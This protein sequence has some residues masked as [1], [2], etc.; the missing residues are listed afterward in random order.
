M[1]KTRIWKWLLLA[2]FAVGSLAVVYPP[3]DVRSADGRLLKTGKIR[4]GLDLKGGS[5][6]VV[7]VDRDALRTQLREENPEMS[8]EGLSDRVAGD[9]RTARDLALE[10]IRNRVDG[11]GIAEP[12]IYPQGEDRIVIQLP[13]IDAAKREE[14]RRTIQSVAFL[15]FRLVHKSSDKWV[16][17]LKTDDLAPK[18]FRWTEIPDERD[19]ET[20]EVLVRDRSA[21]ED[22][23]MD[24]VYWAQLKRFEPH[25]GA[26]FMLERR[27]AADRSVVYKPRYVETAQQLT[28]KY[29]KRASVDYD[30]L[31]RPRISIEFD[32]IGRRRFAQVTRDYAPQGEKNRGNDVG[33]Q[34][35]IIL[36]G[37]LYS[38]PVIR[39][40]IPSGRAEITGQFTIPEARRLS[41]VLR[42]GSLPAPLRLIEERTVDPTLGR[43]SIRTGVRASIIAAALTAAFMAI[44]YFLPGWLANLALL[45]DILLLPLGMWLMAGFLNFFGGLSHAA[46]GGSAQFGALPT[47]TLPGI[48]GIALTLG[49]AVDANVLIFERIREEQKAGK[50]LQ[51]VVSAGYEKAWT[52]ILDSNLTTLLAAV[53]MFWQGSG[54]VR[55]YAITLSAGIVVS[56]YTAIAITRMIFDRMIAN[57]RTEGFRM[58]E[59][60]RSANFDFLGRK[61]Y[62][63]GFSILLTVASV[64]AFVAKGERNFGVDFRGGSSVSFEFKNRK[65]VADIR[66]ALDAAGISGANPQ[67]QG[68]RGEVGDK[69]DETLVV[70]GRFEDGQK[71]G[72]TITTQFGAD[73]YRVRQVDTV[74]PQVGE[75]LKRKGLM[76]L[77]WS[78]LGMII[79]I[80]WRFEFGYAIGA[81]VALL[82][83]AIV[84]VGVFCLFGRELSTPMIAVVLTI[85]GYSVNDTIVVFDRIR[86]QR[87]LYPEKKY[88]DVANLSINQTLSRTLL[89]GSTTIL[90]VLSLLFLGGGAINDFA[91]M[92]LIGVLIGTYSSIF[93]ATPVALLWHREAPKAAKV[94]KAAA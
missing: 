59:W 56:M 13:G 55:G 83:D 4:L 69:A 14:A 61:W 45:L 18:G 24:S 65:P 82:H 7:E 30:Q 48:A 52:T 94:A 34:L 28:G 23:Q 9:A 90:S 53:I 26:E 87:K 8:E 27:E 63:I 44:Y 40:E 22:E 86:E 11:L 10:A 91:L 51:A 42:T 74:G 25:E 16:E 89:T 60:I 71:I 43:D 68:A 35:A 50:R 47:L 46:G 78:M 19:R 3:F 15:E 1:D 12:A 70:Q 79:Y 39:E 49:M 38:S 21:M 20:R 57:G 31:S 72:E 2:L 73:G 88:A 41:N 85:I 75:E 64:A 54:P 5:S 80:T 92:L 77:L 84:A 6:F 29:V 67:Y 81:I 17:R 33:R 62:A 36:D 58:M 93:I 66:A 76:A 32:K 37:R